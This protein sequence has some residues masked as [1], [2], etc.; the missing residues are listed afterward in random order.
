MRDSLGVVAA[1]AQRFGER[2]EFL[3]GFPGDIGPGDAGAQRL[4]VLE[5]RFE[6]LAFV[7]VDQFIHG[8]TDFA[9]HRVGEIGVDHDRLQI[10]HHQ[11]RRV[12][13]GIGVHFQ[14]FVGAFETLVRAFGFP[15]EKAFFPDI[16]PT[17]AAGGF[18]GAVFVG[19]PGVL[20]VGFAR[21][22]MPD[23]PAEVFE[24]RLRVAAFVAAVAPFGDELVRRHSLI[25]PVAI[26]RIMPGVCRRGGAWCAAHGLTRLRQ[27]RDQ[28]ENR[29]IRR[30]GPT[31]PASA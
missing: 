26:D 6:D 3:G 12:L 10:G 17:L 9:L 4:G 11:Q 7:E 30:C 31:Q 21:G 2:G 23:Q 19:E 18:A 24:E 25:A 22:L 1:S 29:P 16:R 20:G 5:D 27:R 13:Q 14:L 28:R 8:K 15:A